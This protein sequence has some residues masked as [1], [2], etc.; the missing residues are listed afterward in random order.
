MC[1]CV[2][3]CMWVYK[4]IQIQSMESNI[5]PHI[6][7]ISWKF[8]LM[9]SSRW[10]NAYLQ[11]YDMVQL[12]K[13]IKP[14]LASLFTNVFFSHTY[15]KPHNLIAAYIQQKWNVTEIS[16]AMDY[17]KTNIKNYIRCCLFLFYIYIEFSK[18]LY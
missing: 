17:C 11:H 4:L 7:I 5:C 16:I 10:V 13:E 18:K 9:N 12:C 15:I 8:V 2:Y 14:F 6:I 3:T 1:T